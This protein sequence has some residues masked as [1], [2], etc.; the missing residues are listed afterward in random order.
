MQ[1][2]KD[3]DTFTDLSCR[4]DFS[5]SFMAMFSVLVFLKCFHW[6]TADRVDYVSTTYHSS[7]LLRSPFAQ[8]DQIP[9][10]GPPRQFHIR[11][12]SIIS[13]LMLLD[14]LFVSYSLETILL[15]GVSAMIIFASEFIIL[16][17]T[18][19]GS[20]ARYA[21]GVIDL[22]RARGREDAPV[23][24]AKSTYLFYIDLS[25]GQLVLRL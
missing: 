7:H 11:M 20:A 13:L 9:P 19:A 12:V 3:V 8:M 2:C 4:D 23:W 16:Q 18:I 17:A 24:E 5:I 14:F 25:V 15:E 1:A 21:V 10:P 6:I 22:R